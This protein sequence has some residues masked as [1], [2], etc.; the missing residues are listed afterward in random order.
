MRIYVQ[1]Y[2]VTDLY[3]YINVY[4]NT[5]SHD[6]HDLKINMCTYIQTYIGHM[7]IYQYMHKHTFV[8]GLHINIYT[9]IHSDDTHDS[10]LLRSSCHLPTSILSTQTLRYPP[11]NFPD[12]VRKGRRLG[13]FRSSC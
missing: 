11:C 9:Y 6:A 12:G 1:T 10:D 13:Q 8:I 2:M 4:T 7:F 5:H 3:I